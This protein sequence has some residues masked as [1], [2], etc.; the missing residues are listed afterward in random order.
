MKSKLKLIL[1]AFIIFT[2]LMFASSCTRRPDIEEVIEQTEQKVEFPETPTDIKIEEVE[3]VEEVEDA[4]VETEKIE[5]YPEEVLKEAIE[6]ITPVFK[7]DP[8]VIESVEEEEE[9]FEIVSLGE[10]RLTAY[11]PC[12]K[13]CGK[14]SGGATA[15]GVMPTANHTIAVDRS[16]I[17]FGTEIIINGVTYVAE[18]TG[19]AIKGNRVD[20]FFDSHKEA[21]NFGVQY[22]EVFKIVY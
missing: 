3:E 18:D 20:I 10:F 2:S 7:A 12:S 21:L 5:V 13:C 16:V 14:W 15:S 8:F 1:F 19:G 17:P 11:C 4:T 6:E 9:K 22:A